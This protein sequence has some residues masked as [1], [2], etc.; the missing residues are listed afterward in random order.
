MKKNSGKNKGGRPDK[1]VDRLLDELQRRINAIETDEILEGQTEEELEARGFLGDKKIEVTRSEHMNRRLSAGYTFPEGVEYATHEPVGSCEEIGREGIGDIAVITP[2]TAPI[3]RPVPQEK[4]ASGPRD[5]FDKQYLEECNLD[6]T[7]SVDTIRFCPKVNGRLVLAGERLYLIPSDM[8]GTFS[9]R[10]VDA[11]MRAL[12]DFRA[13]AGEGIMPDCESVCNELETMGVRTGIKTDRIKEVLETVKTTRESANDIVIAEGKPPVDG[14]DAAVDFKFDTCPTQEEY[15][16]LP[17]GRIDYRKQATIPIVHKGDLL[18]VVSEPSAGIDGY[19]LTGA[20]AKAYQGERKVLCPGM[21]V[22]A[23][24][25]MEYRAECDGQASLNGNVLSVYKQFVVEGNVDY[26]CGNVRFNGNVMVKGNVLSGFE[27]HADGDIIVFGNTDGAVLKAGRDIRVEGGI[28]GRNECVISCGRDLF[29]KHIQ[30]GIVEAQGDVNV[31]NSIV[32]STV[33][34]G[35]TIR[36]D[37][38]KA[39]IIGGAVCA[40]NAVRARTI[41]SEY[42]VRTAVEAGT[43]YQARK[44]GEELDRSARFCGD[45]IKKIDDVFLSLKAMVKKGVSLGPDKKSRVAQIRKKRSQLKKYRE[46]MEWKKK[47][48]E[49]HSHT[50]TMAVICI[51]DK[52][53]ADVMLKIIDKK[54]LIHNTI[55]HICFRYDNKKDRIMQG[56]YS[57]EG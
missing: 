41:G 26:G 8:D 36:L 23:D 52:I 54:L 40:L 9:I 33:S 25:N 34:A 18:A 15:R 4:E 13:P 10:I 29:T 6:I 44:M 5:I 24:E 38:K 21:N 31:R 43:D 19:D 7:V 12:A 46:V 53:F 2:K 1:N 32:Q 42:G 47:E 51:E 17:D 37:G 28:I 35:G 22:T 30:N 11:E 45:N 16:I 27:V 55:S 48:L 39:A 20:V 57:K 3:T 56:E 49:K 14:K 50:N